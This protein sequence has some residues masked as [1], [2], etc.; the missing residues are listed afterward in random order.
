MSH[1][2]FIIKVNERIIIGSSYFDHNLMIQ[3]L[4]TYNNQE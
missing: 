4:A 3:A 2:V 1:V